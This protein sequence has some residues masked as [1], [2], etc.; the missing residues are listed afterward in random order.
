MEGL[1]TFSA[2]KPTS[3]KLFT[4]D[5]SLV[6]QPFTAKT[7]GSIG[8]YGHA[9]I[10]TEDAIITSLTAPTSHDVIIANVRGKDVEETA[11]SGRT[12]AGE[13]CREFPISNH[14]NLLILSIRHHLT[15]FN[16]AE[17]I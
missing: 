15:K 14:L 8:I 10:L 9:P 13:F 12:K 4:T 16:L 6:C 3:T 17:K 2:K 5:C 1:Y 11:I 7:K